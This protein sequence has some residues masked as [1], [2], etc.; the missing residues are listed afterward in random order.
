MYGKSNGGKIKMIKYGGILHIPKPVRGGDRVK[1]L[2]KAES[3]LIIEV[4]TEI[5]WGLN[6]DAELFVHL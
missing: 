6:S 4:G 1:L 3:R 2:K 5:P